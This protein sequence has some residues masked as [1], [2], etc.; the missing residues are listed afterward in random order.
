MSGYEKSPDYGGP[1]P[2]GKFLF[3]FVAMLLI[4]TV[5]S[6][7]YTFADSADFRLCGTVRHTCVVDGDT[8]W[9]RGEKIRLAGIDAPEKSEPKC[10]EEA[11]RAAD[12]TRRLAEILSTHQWTVERQGKD[13]YGR[14]LAVF[15][16]GS[17]TAG[18]ILVREGL[19]RVWRGRRMPWC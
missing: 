16:I 11:V 4:A 14:T 10:A 1:P 15:R 9:L 5:G 6:V 8:V 13:R 12:A 19:A 17:T 7:W 3:L 18:A 2:T